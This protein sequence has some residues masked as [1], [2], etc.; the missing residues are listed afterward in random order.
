[1]NTRAWLYFGAHRLFGKNRG[2][3][4]AAYR[5]DDETGIPADLTQQLLKRLLAHCAQSVPYYSEIMAS[6][7]DA[8]KQSPEAYLAQLPILTK[9]IVNSHFEQLK[10][11]DLS[12]RRWRYERSGGSTGE[13]VR[14]IQD[15]ACWDSQAGLEDLGLY[16]AGREVGEPMVSLWGS[17]R[18]LQGNMGLKM[19]TL[20]WLA[21]ITL[22]NAYRM[23]PEKMR[24][25]LDW[26]NV[27]RPRVIVAYAQA[28]YDLALF[29]ENTGAAVTPQ[30]AI[31]TSA[32]T[33][34]P[35]MR[36]KVESVFGCR[37]F[38]RYG[39]REVGSIACECPHHTGLHVFPWGNYVEIVDDEGQAVPPGT[40]GNILVTSLTNYAM[41]LVRY[42]IGDRGSLAPEGSCLCGRSGQMIQRITGRLTDDFRTRAGRL[43]PGIYF[44]HMIGVALNTGTVKKF[45]VIQEDYERLR[46]ILVKRDPGTN[47]DVPAI[48]AAFELVMGA[49]LQME[50]EYVDEIPTSPSGKYRYT[51]SR[52]GA[53]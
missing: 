48:Q 15:Q 7:G 41:P 10:S 19:T 29:A 45:Q 47:V 12:R 26:L 43:I 50:V 30:Q 49:G 28:I 9:S 1:M 17:E 11:Q 14:V 23:T 34:H 31:L 22:L 20:N 16:W 25:Y 51:I 6:R 18:D 52:V 53:Q 42:Q 21:N 37:V 8:F 24:A 44:V 36:E 27:K 46:L 5:R 33:L 2:G 13:P 40:E 32:S 4:Y 38:D 35:F 3:M 39:C